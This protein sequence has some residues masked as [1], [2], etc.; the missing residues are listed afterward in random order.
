MRQ[1]KKYIEEKTFAFLSFF[2]Y[3]DYYFIFWKQEDKADYL[4]HHGDILTLKTGLG[5][6]INSYETFAAELPPAV[7]ADLRVPKEVGSI[8]W[9]SCDKRAKKKEENK[10]GPISYL[11]FYI[12]FWSSLELALC[13]ESVVLV[14]FIDYW[15]FFFFSFCQVVGGNAMK[16]NQ[17]IFPTAHFCDCGVKNCKFMI[18]WAD[19]ESTI[20]ERTNQCRIFILFFHKHLKSETNLWFHFLSLSISLF[21]CLFWFGLYV[22]CWEQYTFIYLYYYYFLKKKTAHSQEYSL[23]PKIDCSE[24]TWIS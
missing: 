18:R 13:C 2:S 24:N 6:D 10:K 12:I 22:M 23:S 1:I 9:L 21:F 4:V 5:E 8:F 14:M 17:K 20:W 11:N 16:E 7:P 15:V 3:Y 19:S